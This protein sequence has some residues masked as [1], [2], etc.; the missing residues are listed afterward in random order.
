MTTIARKSLKEEVLERVREYILKGYVSPGERI[1]I[2]EL[3]RRLG[4]SITPVREALN[5]LAAEGL[6]TF[7]S[8]RGFTV[9]KWTKKEIEDLL[10]LRSSLEKLAVRLFIERSYEEKLPLLR[11]TLEKMW[12]TLQK[13]DVERLAE[14][15]AEFHKII[16]MGSKNEELEKVMN[17]L[18]DKL[19]RVR[20]LSLSNPHRP[21]QSY[22]EHLEIFQAIEKKDITLA[23][24]AVGKHVLSIKDTL[25]N[26]LPED[27]L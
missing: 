19:Q 20:I 15:N 11:T 2:D 6:L 4:V 1:V 22:E 25:L 26:Q 18:R 3:A 12:Q 8:H 9:K 27:F 17:T 21:K 7:Q 14:L 10:L 5:C 23:E 16:V 13:E 24:K